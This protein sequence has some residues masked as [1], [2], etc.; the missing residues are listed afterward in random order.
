MSERSPTRIVKTYELSIRSPGEVY[1]WLSQRPQDGKDAKRDW[2]EE[3]E[4]ALLDRNEPLIELGL[5]RYST[6]HR[7][8]RRIFTNRL[9]HD[10][11]DTAIRLTLLQYGRSPRLAAEEFPQL[12]FEGGG[13]QVAMASWLSTASDSDI[14]ALFSNRALSRSFLLNFFEQKEV[15]GAIT[16]WNRH[17]AIRAFNANSWF[18]ESYPV[19]NVVGRIWDEYKAVFTAAWK[20]VETVD[21]TLDW[22]TT[23]AA[24]VTRISLVGPGKD[25][26]NIAAR[27]A[28]PD[29]AKEQ[30]TPKLGQLT[31]WEEIRRRLLASGMSNTK[32]SRDECLKSDD[33]AIR[34]I[35]Y[36]RFQFTPDEVK[37]LGAD[38]RAL[39]VNCL[40]GN[41]YM[42]RTKELRCA[43]YALCSDFDRADKSGTWEN[44]S[45]Y[46]CAEVEWKEQ[47]PDWFKDENNAEYDASGAIVRPDEKPVTVGKFKEKIEELTSSVT[48]H[49]DA[50]DQR[51]EGISSI[52][53]LILL[54]VVGLII[55]LV[56][57]G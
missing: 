30:D 2:D 51:L 28:S 54:G 55:Y 45:R 4:M 41:L 12:L 10:Q 50:A 22:A 39:V 36:G 3:T 24:T 16:D 1:E 8:L 26:R 7:V 11:G 18:F 32:E 29:P 52:A 47:E 25:A 21:T 53:V 5:A 57:R 49:F 19:P 27:W 14:T 48:R 56:R 37:V 9:G 46:Q 42:W 33:I 38:E 23:L 17:V 34:A 43:I 6:S 44:L 31:C 20:L 15:W 35:G 40:L 13:G